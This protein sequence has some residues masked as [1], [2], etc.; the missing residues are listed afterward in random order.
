MAFAY[1][2]RSV[3]FTPIFFFSLVCLTEVSSKLQHKSFVS[4]LA[5]DFNQ[6]REL[7]ILCKGKAVSGYLSNETAAETLLRVAG[8]F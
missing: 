3:L 6:I 7:L 5:F 8:T 1:K 4:V 2:F